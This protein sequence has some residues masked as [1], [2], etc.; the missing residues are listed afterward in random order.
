MVF[1][2]LLSCVNN[3]FVE[4]DQDINRLIKSIYFGLSQIYILIYPY[5]V[6]W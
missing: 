2:I 6:L 5:V 4:P 3:K 1:E